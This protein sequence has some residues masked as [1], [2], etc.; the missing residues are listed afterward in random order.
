MTEKGI[1]VGREMGRCGQ[2]TGR[3]P[4]KSWDKTVWGERRAG[5]TETHRQ[6]SLRGLNGEK[7]TFQGS[8][9]E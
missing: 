3:G 6:R 4:Q 5:G 2:R 8:V 7:S 1:N 9:T